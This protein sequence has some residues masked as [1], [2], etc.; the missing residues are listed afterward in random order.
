MTHVFYSR[1]Q[2]AKWLLADIWRLPRGSNTPLLAAGYLIARLCQILLIC[3]CNEEHSR[4]FLPFKNLFYGTFILLKY[5]FMICSMK[6]GVILRYILLRAT[7][8]TSIKILLQESGALLVGV[9]MQERTGCP[10][11]EEEMPAGRAVSI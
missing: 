7:H 5:I 6:E 3:L 11:L 1:E 4:Q 10:A 9:G 8:A 2:R